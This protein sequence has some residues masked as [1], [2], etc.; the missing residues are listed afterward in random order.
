MNILKKFAVRRLWDETDIEITFHD[1][2]NFLI[3]KYGS[4]KTTVINLIA[5]ALSADYETLQGLLFKE[6]SLELASA[7]LEDRTS[8]PTAII[9]EKKERK[10][11][12]VPSIVYT[13]RHRKEEKRYSLNEIERRLRLSEYSRVRTLRPLD[14]PDA[15]GLV[16]RLQGLANLTWLSI[17]RGPARLS[18]EDR[19]FESSIDKKLVELGNSL[20]KFFSELSSRAEGE[21][22][23]FQQTM[24]LSLIPNL[25]DWALFDSVRKLDLAEE[26]NALVEIFRSFKMQ[27]RQFADVVDRHF[28]LLKEAVVETKQ[29]YHNNELAAI[30]GMWSIHRV[31]SEWKVLLEKQ[32][33]ISQPKDNFLA[34][35]NQMFQRKKLII[36]EQN[37]LE[38]LTDNDTI[39]SLPRLSSGEKQLA[40]IL[41]EALLQKQAPWIYIADEPELSLHVTWQEKLTVHLRSI[42]PHSQIIFATH[43]PDIVSTYT[44]R[45]FDME[46]LI[47]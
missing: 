24:F 44:N 23:K 34:V 11:A 12:P 27:E 42:N 21:T 39:L 35:M 45:V 29:S 7:D 41:G 2:V 47:A 19:S 9:V 26:R 13:F 14:D 31:V 6:V 8:E 22:A 3:G 1:D 15:L 25:S 40:I 32:Q 28:A 10:G 20:T 37:E 38:A 30:A 5:A 43:S 36:N 16:E 46:K 17:H 18:R 33:Q 4:G